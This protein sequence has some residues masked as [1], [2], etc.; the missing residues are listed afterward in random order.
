MK[1]SHRFVDASSLVGVAL[2][3]FGTGTIITSLNS[4]LI[5][6]ALSFLYLFLA[7]IKFFE[8]PY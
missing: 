6:F 8:K 7:T 1:I 3:M 5:M 4:K 2:A